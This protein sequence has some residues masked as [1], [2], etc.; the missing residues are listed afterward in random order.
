MRVAR[1]HNLH[2]GPLC[3][4]TELLWLLIPVQS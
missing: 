2:Y 3:S 1:I 4:H